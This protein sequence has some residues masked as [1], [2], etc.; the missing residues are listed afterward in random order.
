[1][2]APVAA[3]AAPASAVPV[4]APAGLGLPVHILPS[5]VLQG[6]ERNNTV[7]LSTLLCPVIL[8]DFVSRIPRVPILPVHHRNDV[9]PG[10]G[11]N[12]NPLRIFFREPLHGHAV[13]AFVGDK[14]SLETVVSEVA[15]PHRIR[16]R[17]ITHQKPFHAQPYIGLFPGLV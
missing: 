11:Q 12:K 16:I 6:P 15:A 9:T 17:E 8:R 2:A 1:M 14:V 7:P 3:S 4:A 5:A 10:H 13:R